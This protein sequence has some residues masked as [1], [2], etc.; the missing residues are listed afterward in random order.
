MDD[1]LQRFK[2]FRTGDIILSSGENI[3]DLLIFVGRHS[4]IQHSCILVWLN[5]EALQKHELKVEPNFIDEQTTAL[6]FLGLAE[7]SRTDMLTGEKQKGLILWEPEELMKNAPIVY[8]RELN[9]QYISNEY[10]C[11][12]MDEYIRMHHLKMK[13]AYGKGHIVT[14][15]LGFD[16]FGEHQ[17]KGVLC[18][19]NIYFFLEHLC[20]YPEFR[21][22]GKEV[23]HSPYKVVDAIR[24]MYVP[25]FFFSENNTHPVFEPEE[26]RVISKKNEE[27]VTVLN[28]LLITF[29]VLVLI[30]FFGFLIISRF[31]ESCSKSGTCSTTGICIPGPDIFDFI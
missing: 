4:T 1:L 14:V 19:E 28:P 6:S 24:R 15:G 10:V 3:G 26:Y 22:D 21:I 23:P 13:Y 30:I 31:C 12:K 20:E 17:D 5:T 7:G 2:N 27:D 9:K 11:Q 29:V 18:S 25:D 8:V 16:V